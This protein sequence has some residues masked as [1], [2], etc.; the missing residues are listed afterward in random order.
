MANII[1][2]IG[3]CNKMV[4]KNTSQI[5]IRILTC[6][7][8]CSKNKGWGETHMKKLFRQEIR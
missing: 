5:L 1:K 8:V 4:T 2:L 6:I 3:N 7:P